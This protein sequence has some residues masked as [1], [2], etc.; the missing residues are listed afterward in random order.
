MRLPLQGGP[1]LI[2]VEASRKQRSRLQK[3]RQRGQPKAKKE[4][5]ICSLAANRGGPP[6]SLGDAAAMSLLN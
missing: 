4:G 2:G 5:H 1:R 6:K 3:R